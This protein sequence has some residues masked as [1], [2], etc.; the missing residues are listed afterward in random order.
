MTALTMADLMVRNQVRKEGGWQFLSRIGPLNILNVL[1]L[2]AMFTTAAR[3][4]FDLDLLAAQYGYFVPLLALTASTGSWQ[5]ELF[6]GIGEKYL[7]RAR[8]V[9]CTR[10][11]TTLVECSLPFTMFVVLIVIS[12]LESRVFHLVTAA[13]ML[14]CFG[15]LGTALGFWVGF[16]HE[17]AVNNFL[18]LIT[19]VLGF[20]PGPFFGKE[21]VG[22][23]ALFP[24]GFSTKGE[25]ELEWIKLAVLA[26]AAVV[27]VSFGSR[28]RRQRFFAS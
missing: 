9:W 23:T 12:D 7:L 26:V 24:G 27:L 15:M 11:F 25:F 28:A 22:L 20:G 8:W 18:N 2:S 4:S 1:L 17:K 13:A 21:G 10:A 14:I 16:R 19:W 3:T 6:S 5:V